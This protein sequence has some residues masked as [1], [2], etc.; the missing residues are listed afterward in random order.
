MSPPGSLDC[1]HFRDLL[2]Q[3]RE[4]LL[5][6]AGTG[7]EAANTVELDQSRVGRLSRMNALQSQAMSRETNRRR[8]VELS[9]IEAALQRIADGDYGLCVRCGEEIAEGRLLSD[10]SAPLCIDCASRA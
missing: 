5:D 10:P 4:A 3:R 6:V 8:E 9:R 7:R 2:L 1:R